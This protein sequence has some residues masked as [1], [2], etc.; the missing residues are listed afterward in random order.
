[1]NALESRVEVGFYDQEAGYVFTET[2]A[3]RSTQAYIEVLHMSLFTV[4]ALHRISRQAMADAL[5][6]ALYK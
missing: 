1:M 4:W 5:A 2:S 6:S 3:S